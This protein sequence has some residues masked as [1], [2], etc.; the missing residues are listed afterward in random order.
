M[1][2]APIA[3]A[4]VASTSR[5]AVFAAKREKRALPVAGDGRNTALSPMVRSG[6]VLLG[7]KGAQPPQFEAVRE[8]SDCL[9]L[10]RQN[11]R[12]VFFVPFR[13]PPKR[14]SGSDAESFARDGL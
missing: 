11:K 9:Q 6:I 2:R 13:S 3:L 7:L 12:F 4:A 5:A 14:I 8:P 1:K 10:T